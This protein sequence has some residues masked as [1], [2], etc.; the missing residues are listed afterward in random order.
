MHT[1]WHFYIWIKVTNISSD[2]QSTW[3]MC[4]QSGLIPGLRFSWW[5]LCLLGFCYFLD[6]CAVSVACIAVPARA[7]VHATVRL[8]GCACCSYLQVHSELGL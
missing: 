6:D 8:C 4:L 5:I 2:S 1:K 7:F 3:E